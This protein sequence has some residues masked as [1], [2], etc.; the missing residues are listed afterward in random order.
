[1]AAITADISTKSNEAPKPRT[2]GQP[3]LALS[4][5]LAACR[6]ASP[7]GVAFLPPNYVPFLLPKKG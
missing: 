1:M 3:D 6:F 4:L 2:G 7:A 5:H